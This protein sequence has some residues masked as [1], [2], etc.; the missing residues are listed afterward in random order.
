[1]QFKRD[2]ASLILAGKK[3]QTRRVAPPRWKVGSR[4]PI[5]CGYRCKALGYIVI[6]KVWESTLNGMTDEDLEAEGRGYFKNICRYADY[7]AE[8]NGGYLNW[9]DP[10]TV[11]EFHL[12]EP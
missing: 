7:L 3:T 12:E 11:Y 10:L 4:Q 1:M 6:D 9:S 2:M 8:I 5:Q